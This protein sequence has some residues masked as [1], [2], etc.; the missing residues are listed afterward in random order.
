TTSKFADPENGKS[1]FAGLADV[2][3]D[4]AMG[5]RTYPAK[6]NRNLRVIAD[7]DRFFEFGKAT[8]EFETDQ[9]DLQLQNRLEVDPEFTVDDASVIL[10]HN[11]QKLRLPKG[12]AAFDQPFAS[13]WPRDSREVESERHLANIHGTFY[14]VPLLL[15][16][17]PPAFELMRP[18]ASHNKQISDY[19]TWNGLLVL[20]GVRQDAQAD[21]HVFT[22]LA[23]KVGL[24]FGGV[25]DLWK[26]GKPVGV[27]G[28]WKNTKVTANEPSDPYLMTG[29]DSKTITLSS[30]VDTV[31]TI[32]V[33][34]DHQTGFHDYLDIAVEG[35]ES[36]EHVF[37]DSFSAH[38][39]RVRS[40]ETATATAQLVYR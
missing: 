33:D 3:A 17:K 28:P 24:W 23:K 13:G 22:D 12:H 39:I 27:G 31:F 34:F 5:S 38:W 32:E 4:N 2:D 40:S 37:P 25:D 21:G 26:F 20:S 30:D 1:L 8:F 7:G 15:N 35:G 29:Y 11:G 9:P 14:E 36:V 6:R 18:V 19:C 10:M 16:G